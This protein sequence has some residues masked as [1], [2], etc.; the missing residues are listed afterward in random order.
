MKDDNQE[1]FIPKV[2]IDFSIAHL[3]ILVRC[4]TKATVGAGCGPYCTI[5]N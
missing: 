2:A 1:K 5:D 4:K 3:P